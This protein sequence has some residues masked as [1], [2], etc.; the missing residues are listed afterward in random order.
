ML[1]HLD[2]LVALTWPALDVVARVVF[3]RL[4]Q[5]RLCDLYAIGVDEVSYRRSQRYLTLVAN[6]ASGAVVWADTGRSQATLERLFDQLG[7][8]EAAKIRAVSLDMC[9]PA[10]QANVCFDPSTSSPSPTGRRYRP[11]A[12]VAGAHQAAGGGARWLNHAPG[13]CSS[14]LSG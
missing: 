4:D 14:D 8:D 10:P 1:D 3:S 6:H 7:D 13:A 11:P 9:A 5:R 12:G 2:V